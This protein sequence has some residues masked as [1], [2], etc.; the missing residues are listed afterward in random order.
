MRVGHGYGR[1]ELGIEPPPSSIRDKTK[2][3]SQSRVGL[4][5]K[6]LNVTE[7]TVLRI[8]DRPIEYRQ[9]YSGLRS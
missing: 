3:V 4:G 5:G 2:V 7:R 1:P 8:T 6:D 9:V